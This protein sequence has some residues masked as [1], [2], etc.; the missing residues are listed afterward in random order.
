MALNLFHDAT[1]ALPLK[2]W[3]IIVMNHVRSPNNEKQLDAMIK[4]VG[5]IDTRDAKLVKCDCSDSGEVATILV[6]Q[7]ENLLDSEVAYVDKMRINA[8]IEKQKKLE[9]IVHNFLK[10]LDRNVETSAPSIDGE[11]PVFQDGGEFKKNFSKLHREMR[12]L[13]KDERKQAG[14]S[15]KK[16]TE[17]KKQAESIIDEI[18]NVFD[19]L[20]ESPED[21][22]EQ[23]AEGLYLLPPSKLLTLLGTSSGFDGAR[24]TAIITTRIALSKILREKMDKILGFEMKELIGKVE[25]IL[26]G[27]DL[28]NIFQEKEGSFFERLSK[29]LSEQQP[30]SELSVAFQ[31]LLDFRKNFNYDFF[32]LPAI[33]TALETLDYDFLTDIEDPND[34]RK[35]LT[36]FEPKPGSSFEEQAKRIFDIVTSEVL[37]IL[38]NIESDQSIYGHLRGIQLA[39][40]NEFIDNAFRS[41]NAEKEWRSFFREHKQKIWPKLYENVQKQTKQRDEWKSTIAR[42]ENAIEESAKG[43][44]A[45]QNI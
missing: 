11:D 5:K 4:G 18:K 13:I 10:V 29:E 19:E 25:E 17:I 39:E 16:E 15:S 42:L 3:C 12:Q 40:L 24:S 43:T 35:N 1:E 26:K 9:E 6:P 8:V 31:S 23:K 38:H 30:E 33:R 22:K 32:F 36:H 14:A 37:S 20:L 44:A 41:Q 45:I 7:I 28:G 2:H 21:V 34:N 27:N